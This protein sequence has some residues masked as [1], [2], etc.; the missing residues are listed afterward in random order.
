MPRSGR[1][2]RGRPDRSAVTTIPDHDRSGVVGTA[3]RI[4]RED[5]QAMAQAPDY[6]S[7]AELKARALLERELGC[8][9][10]RPQESHEPTVD[11]RDGSG[12]LVAASVRTKRAD[13]LVQRI[14]LWLASE[15]SQN[16]RASLANESG[17]E[18]HA[19]LVFDAL[20]EP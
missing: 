7:D 12:A 6:E 9:L 5:T 2:L 13:T 10:R 16:L 4:R 8:E 14:D 19:V 3:G 11:Y 1:H 17:T 20:T 15:H 18:R